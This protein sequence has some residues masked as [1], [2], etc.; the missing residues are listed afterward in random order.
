MVHTFSGISLTKDSANDLLGSILGADR[1]SL[2]NNFPFS[3]SI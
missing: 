3:F 1:N 2:C